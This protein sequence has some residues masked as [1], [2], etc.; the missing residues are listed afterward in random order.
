MDNSGGLYT[1]TSHPQTRTTGS[2]SN[3]AVPR[4]SAVFHGH[5]HTGGSWANNSGQ[6]TNTVIDD[7]TFTSGLRTNTVLA[8]HE[9][10]S[11]SGARTNKRRQG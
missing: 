4:A 8:V 2:W 3:T 9:R 10:T 6:Q 7:V 11:A 5:K 1:N